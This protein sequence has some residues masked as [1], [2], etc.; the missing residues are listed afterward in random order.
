MTLRSRGVVGA[1][2]VLALVFETGCGAIFYPERRGQKGGR[3]DAGV[4]VLDG[5]GLLFFILPGVIAFAVD[6]GTG[7]I[8]I[9]TGG[10]GMFGMETTRFA[11][12]PMEKR[13]IE[14]ALREKTGVAVSL[15]D[16]ALQAFELNSVD[17]LP[18]RFAAART[19]AAR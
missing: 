19:L 3:I 5:I 13:D 6:F 10:K 18:A 4:A 8:Y 7:A 2:V 15:D 1:I 9:P 11:A 12:G 14:R 17:E 16:P